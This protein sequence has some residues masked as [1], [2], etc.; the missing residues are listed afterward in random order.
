[1]LLAQPVITQLNCEVEK[2]NAERA[3]AQ[4][5]KEST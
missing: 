5:A 2:L 1:M 4:F 3:A